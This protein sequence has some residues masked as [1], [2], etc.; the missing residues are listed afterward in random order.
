MQDLIVC[1]P[2]IIQGIADHRLRQKLWPAILGLT[3]HNEEFS[4]EELET[5]YDKYENQWLSVLPD[6]ENRFTAFRERKSILGMLCGGDDDYLNKTKSLFPFQ[7][8]VRPQPE[9]D[10]VR[11]DRSHPFFRESTENLDLL[12]QLLMTYIMYDFDTGYVQGKKNS[13]SSY[14]YLSI[15][16][17]LPL[18]QRLFLPLLTRGF[19]FSLPLLYLYTTNNKN[20][21]HLP[22]TVFS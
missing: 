11:C 16:L 17:P 7:S 12:R 13:L 3:K 2:F 8:I 22:T 10:V 4:W 14:Y 20:A 19:F 21:P 1:L 9:R 6:Q 18:L 5:L 15:S